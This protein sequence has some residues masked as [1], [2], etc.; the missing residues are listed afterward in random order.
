MGK[1]FIINT[2]ILPT[3][4]TITM[5][6]PI[7]VS[8]TG[9]T[10]LNKPILVTDSLQLSTIKYPTNTTQTGVLWNS[11]NTGVAIVSNSGLVTVI[12]V[13][14]VTITATSMSNGVVLD[15]TSFSCELTSPVVPITAIS[16]QSKPTS[17]IDAVQLSYTLTPSNTTQTGVTWSSSVTSA[18]TVSNTGLITVAGVG[19][20][21]IT[22]TSSVNSEI[23]DSFSSTT[24]LTT[25]P[26]TSLTISGSDTATVGG[27]IQ[28]YGDI[29]PG[30][31]TDTSVTWSSS[32]TDV[33]IVSASGLVT[34]LS[35]G[36]T[37]ITATSVSNNS[38]SN[39]K[40]ITVNSVVST[41]HKLYFKQSISVNGS[42][43]WTWT[44]AK[45]GVKV[46]K[47][48][49]HVSSP[50]TIIN[51][52]GTTVGSI[53]KMTGTEMAVIDANAGGNGAFADQ[54]LSGK[55]SAD[56]DYDLTM[57]KN[58][59]TPHPFVANAAKSALGMHCPNG[60]YHYKILLGCVISR[61]T[62]QA[63]LKINGT[64]IT[65]PVFDCMNNVNNYVEGDFVVTTGYLMITLDKQNYSGTNPIGLSLTEIDMT[66]IG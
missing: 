47:S 2:T 61:S 53:T 22:L 48:Y 42:S 65:L 15:T 7:V 16:I 54:I 11:S 19:I 64:T 21:T 33:A 60:T 17:I 40:V 6:D 66:V 58:V 18:A 12:S 51:S 38:I 55:T 14:S 57:I 45:S 5:I 1:A 25:I 30:D 27:T 31:A 29:L 63:L 35:S 10:I 50:T 49:I 59:C 41:V 37:T 32:N 4:G 34:T 52:A 20:T 39:T 24:S 56:C 43:S 62:S 36:T 3:I 26:V 23:F 9:I 8:I 28:L 13:G 44:D 46:N